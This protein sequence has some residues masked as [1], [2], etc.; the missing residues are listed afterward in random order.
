MNW[1]LID[2]T[3]SGH[4]VDSTIYLKPKQLKKMVEV[5]KKL[6]K[7]MLIYKSRLLV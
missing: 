3:E 7:N 4:R 2:M 6:S 5:S 1:K